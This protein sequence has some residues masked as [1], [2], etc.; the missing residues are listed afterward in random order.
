MASIGKYIVCSPVA[1][2]GLSEAAW[3]GISKIRNI[4]MAPKTLSS[5]IRIGKN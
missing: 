3:F 5:L 2:I 4:S 1:E